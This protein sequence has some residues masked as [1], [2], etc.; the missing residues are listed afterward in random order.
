MHLIYILK[1]INYWCKWVV[2]FFS[3]E[4]RI[5][6]RKNGGEKNRRRD[7]GE[8]M[9]IFRSGG[10]LLFEK[11]WL[12]SRITFSRDTRPRMCSIVG[13]TGPRCR[14]TFFD[15]IVERSKT[16]FDILFF[17]SFSFLQLFLLILSLMI[18]KFVKHFRLL[19]LARRSSTFRV[20]IL[21]CASFEWR[22]CPL[23][24]SPPKVEDQ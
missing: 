24:L 21:F 11:L 5:V 23:L 10:K 20:M 22:V 9:I 6:W 2:Y 14:V 8:A 4:H 12:E 7:L 16:P 3:L 13:T 1:Y 15:K 19:S 17:F 18:L